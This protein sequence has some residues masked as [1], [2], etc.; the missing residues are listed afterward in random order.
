MAG[1]H[2]EQGKEGS[3]LANYTESGGKGTTAINQEEIV[4]VMLENYEICCNLFHGFD[5]SL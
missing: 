4:A 1:S 2:Q 5:W 3:A